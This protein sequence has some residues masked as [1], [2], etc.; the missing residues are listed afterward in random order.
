MTNEENLKLNFL[1]PPCRPS[2]LDSFGN[3]RLLLASV[4]RALPQMKGRVLDIGCG[5][6]PYKDL[7]LTEAASVESYVSLD[8]PSSV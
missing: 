7:V 8:L 3:R 1:C 2:T 4:R 5:Q 6:M